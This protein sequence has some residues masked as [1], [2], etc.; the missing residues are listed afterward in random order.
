M[1]QAFDEARKRNLDIQKYKTLGD[2]IAS[3]EMKPKE[4]EKPKFDPDKAK[5]FS[6]KRTVTTEGG[7]VFTVYDVENTEEG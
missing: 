4:K 7:R 1:R 3:P 2:L 5:T 6:N